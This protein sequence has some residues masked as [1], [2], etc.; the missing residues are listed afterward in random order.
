VAAGHR[1]SWS[2]A[3]L[4]ANPRLEGGAPSPPGWAGWRNRNTNGP[5]HRS[6]PTPTA[7]Q[8]GKT[9]S[10]A[11]ELTAQTFAGECRDAS[12]ERTGSGCVMFEKS[13]R[14]NDSAPTPW[15]AGALGQIDRLAELSFNPDGDY[16][17]WHPP[18]ALDHS[19]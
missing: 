11:N 14:S 9:P 3:A 4:P 10:E 1:E 6:Q 5:L 18:I 12:A 15:H 17:C 13:E 7:L 19:D 16:C 2:D 8:L